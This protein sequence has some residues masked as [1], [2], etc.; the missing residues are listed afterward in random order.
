MPALPLVCALIA[1]HPVASMSPF[2]YARHALSVGT[3]LSSACH[4]P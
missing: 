3:L 4:L 2:F 1:T